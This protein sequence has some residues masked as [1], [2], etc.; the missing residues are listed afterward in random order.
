[1]GQQ[2]RSLGKERHR[3]RNLDAS[4]LSSVG[5][6]PLWSVLSPDRMSEHPSGTQTVAVTLFLAVPLASD[7]F[8]CFGVQHADV[9]QLHV[10]HWF[11]VARTGGKRKNPEEKKAIVESVDE[12]SPPAS[13][14]E[15]LE[16]LILSS[17]S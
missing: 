4:L 2:G 5:D 6:F 16:E 17:P 12:L 1:M 7:S 9:Y 13:P 3:N 14:S 8:G 11:S 15:V 10:F